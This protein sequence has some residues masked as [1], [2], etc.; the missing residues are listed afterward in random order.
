MKSRKNTA[1]LTAT[2]N[3]TILGQKITPLGTVG[4]YV[5]G[6]KAVYPSSVL[7]NVSSGQ[8]SRCRTDRDD[9]TARKR[10]KDSGF[11]SGG[12]A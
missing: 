1:G 4:V 3:G 9:D 2:E 8:G 5:P 6:G 11:H 7:M 10:R 12:G